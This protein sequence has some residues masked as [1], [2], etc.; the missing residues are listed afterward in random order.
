MHQFIGPNFK[1]KSSTPIKK[2]KTKEMK[3]S[4]FKYGPEARKT[5]NNEINEFKC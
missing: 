3:V 5:I 1:K 2:S 4:V